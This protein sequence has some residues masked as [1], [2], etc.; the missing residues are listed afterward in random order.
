MVLTCFCP[1]TLNLH[2]VIV[3]ESTIQWRLSAVQVE[4]ELAVTRGSEEFLEPTGSL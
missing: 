1:W 2:I 4:L 3:L